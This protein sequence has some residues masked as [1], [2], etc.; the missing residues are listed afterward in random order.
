MKPVL[1]MLLSLFVVACV[2]APPEEPPSET[3]GP[4]VVL[5]HKGKKTMELPEPAAEAHLEHGDHLGPC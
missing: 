4:S 3:K 1:M 2:S 5:C